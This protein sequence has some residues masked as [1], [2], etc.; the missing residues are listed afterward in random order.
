[1]TMK[2]P[3][4]AGVVGLDA[5]LLGIGVRPGDVAARRAGVI[6]SFDTAGDE[7]R[8]VALFA[9]ALTGAFFAVAL[10]GAFFAV[11]LTGAFFAVA[12][13][14]AL[15]VVFFAVAFF[16]VGFL[17]AVLFVGTIYLPSAL[18]SSRPVIT[19]LKGPLGQEARRPCR[20]PTP[21]H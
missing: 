13:T 7:P 21:H 10:T 12:L 11:A 14:G 4:W 20:A 6:P 9:V 19:S 1:M 5:R 2:S 15:F 16:T 17:P 3:G 8:G 18:V